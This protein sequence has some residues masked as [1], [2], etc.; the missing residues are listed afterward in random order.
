MFW[1]SFN[2]AFF[3]IFKFYYIFP[4]R[5]IY[6]KDSGLC[7]MFKERRNGISNIWFLFHQKYYLIMEINILIMP[8]LFHFINTSKQM[9]WLLSSVKDTVF[10]FS[11]IL[12]E[13]SL[14]FRYI[15]FFSLSTLLSPSLPS[16]S[17]GNKEI[18]FAIFD[19]A[20]I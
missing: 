13:T 2:S 7:L 12:S 10:P 19:G 6:R 17:L 16:L 5:I 20:K 18:N 15:P 4:Y 1:V 3:L 14:I 11:H 9:A 8:G